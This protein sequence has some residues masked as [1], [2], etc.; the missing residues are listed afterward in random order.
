MADKEGNKTKNVSTGK[1]LASGALWVAPL[2]TALPTDAVTQLGEEFEHLGYVSSDGLTDTPERE[3]EDMQAWGGDT[4]LNVT[5][6]Y[7]ETFT[8]TLIE[9]MRVSVLK[10]V[11]GDDAVTGTLDTGIKIEKSSKELPHKVF[12]ADIA[13]QGDIIRR[14]VVADGK[15][16][17][18]GEIS[19]KD[20]ELIGYETTLKA[21]PDS[22]GVTSHEYIAKAKA[23]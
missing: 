18:V 9:A 1:P 19:Y 20:D 15:V 4:V 6:S 13:M 21:Y 8:Y 17:E 7:S 22:K 10:H 5:T 16:T 11:Y 14:I 23:V 3:T 2:G 12:V